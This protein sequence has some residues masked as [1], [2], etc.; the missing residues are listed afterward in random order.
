VR[1][2]FRVVIDVVGHMLGEKNVTSIAAAHH[3]LG[4]V[5]SCA[6]NIGVAAKIDDTVHRSAMHTR[7][8]E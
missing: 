7:P 3:S 8:H 5:N 2:P 1:T 6:G 4:N